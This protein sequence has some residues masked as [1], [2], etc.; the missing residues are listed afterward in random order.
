VRFKHVGEH[1]TSTTPRHPRSEWL[2]ADRLSVGKLE[3]II[4]WLESN[5]TS[6]WYGEASLY[7]EDLLCDRLALLE[8]IE[9]LKL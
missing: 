4:S 2:E 6:Q 7:I 3:E 5:R 8:D 9:A 1:G